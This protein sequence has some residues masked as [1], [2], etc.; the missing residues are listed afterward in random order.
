[1]K[2][3]L[4]PGN[5]LFFVF[6]ILLLIPTTRILIQSRLLRVFLMSPDPVEQGSN[7]SG[8]SLLLYDLND[9]PESLSF[10]KGK[11]VVINFWATW[12]G[13]CVAEMPSIEKLYDAYQGK[14]DFALISGEES[15]TLKKF[16]AKNTYNLPVFHLGENLPAELESNILPTTYLIGA[17]GAIL[18]SET[19]AKNWNSDFVREILDRE[20]AK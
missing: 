5:I 14:V 12:C 19:G 10:G 16:M 6:L 20:L 2:K 1:M 13:P 18:I 11:P 9:A 7:L 15:E 17:D 8:T 3:Y 4:T